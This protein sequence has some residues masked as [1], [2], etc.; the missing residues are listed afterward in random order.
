MEGF[1][2]ECWHCGRTFAADR[3]DAHFCTGACKAAYNREQGEDRARWHANKEH[4][5]MAYCDWCGRPYWYNDY[6]KRTG[7]RKARF[8]S[9]T[10]RH[11]SWRWEKKWSNIP[12]DGK[13]GQDREKRNNE[14]R[15][16]NEKT[17][18]K[19]DERTY[20]GQTGHA[21]PKEAPRIEWWKSRDPY[22]VL[23]IN[24][25]GPKA[26][27][28]RKYIELIKRWHPDQCNDP[29]ATEISQAINAAWD[30]VKS[31]L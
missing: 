15:H 23:G 8:C 13:A 4:E 14:K 17:G 12:G 16:Q 27:A 1:K 11:K 31:W 9:D 6:A 7:Q 2:R 22:Q 28:R 26:E 30:S 20:A 3:Q 29:M 21:G 18:S 10:C 5:N 19:N 25:G 24:R